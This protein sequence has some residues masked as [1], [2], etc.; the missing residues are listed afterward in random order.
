MMVIYLTLRDARGDGMFSGRS[1]ARDI[2][3]YLQ[4]PHLARLSPYFTGSFSAGKI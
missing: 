1:P 4:V 2:V 3:S